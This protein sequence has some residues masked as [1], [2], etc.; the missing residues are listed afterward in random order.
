MGSHGFITKLN[1]T[2]SALVYSTLLGGTGADNIN[3]IA[4]DNQGGQLV[5]F[6]VYYAV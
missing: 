2:G 6:A 3:K 1:L 4:I 5:R